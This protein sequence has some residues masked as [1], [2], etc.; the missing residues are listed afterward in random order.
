MKKIVWPAASNET[1]YDA[2]SAASDGEVGVLGSGSDYTAF[3]HNG[4]SSLDV[5]ADPGEDD[6]VYHYHR[7]ILQS[8]DFPNTH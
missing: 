7:Y 1:L 8:L 3:L 5:G 2:W 4:I 6:P